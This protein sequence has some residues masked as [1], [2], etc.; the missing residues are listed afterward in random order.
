MRKL[1]RHTMMGETGKFDKTGVPL[2]VSLVVLTWTKMVLLTKGG[3]YYR[4]IGLVEVTLKLCVSIIKKR[5]RSSITLHD[6][7]HGFI[8]G[9]GTGT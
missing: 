4:G 3:G 9:L 7:L 5:L 8:K 2:G 6:S 1:P